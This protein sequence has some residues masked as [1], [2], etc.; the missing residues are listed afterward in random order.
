MGS[1]GTSSSSSKPWKGQAKYLKQMYGRAGE[2]YDQ[3]PYE[4]GPGR[5]AGFDPS[6]Q[7]AFGMAEQ[8]AQGTSLGRAGREQLES[9]IQ[10]DYLDVEKQ[11]WLQDYARGVQRN[12]YGAVNQLGS[13]MEA[14]GRSGSGAQGRGAAVAEENL[15][16][17]LSTLYGGAYESERG[18]QMQATGMMGDVQRQDYQNISALRNVGMQREQQRQ[19]EID[20]MVQRFQFTQQANAQKLAEFGQMIGAP[21]MESKSKSFQMSLIG[22]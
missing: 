5:V 7:Q 11:P 8:R 2:L 20:D 9:T 13:R 18:R 22:G 12:Y 1:G 15:S 21:V 16:R 4:Y 10:G 19:R 14:A 6:S 3:G 17:G